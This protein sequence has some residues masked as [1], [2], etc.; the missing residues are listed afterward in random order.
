MLFAYHNVLFESQFM[1]V[2]FLK[3]MMR[4]IEDFSYN[5]VL[6]YVRIDS[7]GTGNRGFLNNLTHWRRKTFICYLRNANLLEVGRYWMELMCPPGQQVYAFAGSAKWRGGTRWMQ[8]VG[9]IKVSVVT[10]PQDGRHLHFPII[11]TLYCVKLLETEI[12]LS[13][14]YISEDKPR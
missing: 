12:C 11:N 4:R 1:S 13:R 5:L 14:S 9:E 6:V 10:T 2:K 7:I 3:S 8:M